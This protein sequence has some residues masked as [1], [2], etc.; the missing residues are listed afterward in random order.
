METQFENLQQPDDRP[1]YV[2]IIK[3]DTPLQIP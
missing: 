2:E 3:D 1:T